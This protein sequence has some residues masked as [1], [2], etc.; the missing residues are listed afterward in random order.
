M[1]IYAYF[2]LLDIVMNNIHR[3]PSDELE[4]APSSF[5][6][7]SCWVR[8]QTRVTSFEGSPLRAQL[9]PDTIGPWTI[10]HSHRMYESL[11]LSLYVYIYI[12]ATPARLI[13][14]RIISMWHKWVSQLLDSNMEPKFDSNHHW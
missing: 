6:V 2:C 10:C 11:S 8:D 7:P 14:L 12:R 1:I 13:F 4:K 9:A 3:F 5:R